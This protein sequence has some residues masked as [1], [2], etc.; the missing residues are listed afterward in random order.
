MIERFPESIVDG[1][2]PV[3][4]DGYGS[5]DEAAEENEQR[6]GEQKTLVVQT[7]PPPPAYDFKDGL[8]H[9]VSEDC[10]ESKLKLF[11]LRD[12]GT[13][14]LERSL[15]HP[16]LRAQEAVYRG[17]TCRAARWGP[18]QGCYV[19]NGRSGHPIEGAETDWS[20]EMMPPCSFVSL[21]GLVQ[22]TD[23]VV[24]SSRDVEPPRVQT[25]NF[26]GEVPRVDQF[27]DHMGRIELVDPETAM[28]PSEVPSDAKK[29]NAEPETRLPPGRTRR[30]APVQALS[31]TESDKSESE[32]SS[33]DDDDDGIGQDD[34]LNKLRN[35][36]VAQPA[37]SAANHV[38]AGRAPP[39]LAVSASTANGT[40][41]GSS[42]GQSH[43]QPQH[44][45]APAA[46][47][48]LIG[49]PNWRPLLR[50]S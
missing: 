46:G 37:A 24:Q 26:V 28:D 2:E 42:A 1:F 27:L 45:A 48:A 47:A 15:V 31:E 25:W 40:G 41:L 3:S 33:D 36:S 4:F 10:D 50:Q 21:C 43:T 9:S 39:G 29:Y 20:L 35:T 30:V 38:P 23:G 17:F 7:A 16:G 19:F 18:E 11:N 12:T 6:E 22:Q 34:V 13:G 5:D 49:G 14:M 8:M 44:A 32:E